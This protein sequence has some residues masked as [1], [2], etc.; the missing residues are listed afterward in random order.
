MKSKFIHFDT[1]TSSYIFDSNN[2]SKNTQNSFKTSFKL[3][4]TLY[5][6]KK[7]Y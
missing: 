1:S 2:N 7:I 6:V 4:E 3:L 5:N